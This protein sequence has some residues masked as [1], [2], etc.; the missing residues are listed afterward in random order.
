MAA[1]IEVRENQEESNG[2]E[3]RKVLLFYNPGAGNGMFKINLD[4]IIE[5]FQKENKIVIPVRADG[6]VDIVELL[7]DINKDE[8]TKIIAAGG[9]GTINIVVNAMMKTGCILPIAIFPAGTAN[10]YAYYFS[11]PNNID[12]MLDIATG[13]KYVAADIGRCNNRYFV[14]VA[15]IGSVIDVSQKTD[16]SMKN[17]LGIMAYYLKGLSELR[18]LKPVQVRITTDKRQFTENIFFMVVLN[19]NSAGGFRKLGVQSSINDGL[20][21]VIIFKETRFSELP[22]LALDVLHGRHPDN[23][24]VLYFQ[25]S[26]IRIESNEKISTDV[27][28][29]LGEPFPLDIEIVPKRLLVNVSA[30]EQSLLSVAEDFPPEDMKPENAENTAEEEEAASEPE[31]DTEKEQEETEVSGSAS[32]ID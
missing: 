13:N 30:T 18:T 4:K 12:G 3:R 27:D 25:T 14:N 20:F 19:G 22:L 11:I 10:D 21:D 23:D 2:K 32:G 28:G 8:F 1:D 31:K 15:A 5:R 29:E 7:S 17:A 26:Y 6:S 9:D 24:N 16:K